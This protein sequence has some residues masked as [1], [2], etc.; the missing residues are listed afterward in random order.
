MKRSVGV[1]LVV[2]LV[3]VGIAG[4]VFAGV[5]SNEKTAEIENSL[6]IPVDSQQTVGTNAETDGSQNLGVSISPD[7]CSMILIGTGGL[8]L[9]IAKKWRRR[10]V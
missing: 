7:P 1:I 6:I 4:V 9:L 2:V 10:R 5:K 3:A 8:V